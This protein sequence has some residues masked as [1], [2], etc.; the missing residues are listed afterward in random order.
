VPAALVLWALWRLWQRRHVVWNG[1]RTFLRDVWALLWGAVLDVVAMVWRILGSAS[2]SILNAAPAAIR[3]R[4]KT[5][6]RRG[7][8][9]G[10][11]WLRLRGLSARQLIL[12]FYVSLVQRAGL[13]GWERRSGQT[14]YEYSREL[15][16]KLPDRRD[17]VRTLTE[18]FVHAKYSRRPVE[19]EDARRA[20]R[21]WERI[22]GELQTRRQ[23]NRLASWFG[24]GGGQTG[25][26][27][28]TGQRDK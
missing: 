19:D 26:T 8:G 25:Q 7:G 28:Q 20:R 18:A 1:L 12:Y 15:E 2:P 24:L 21:P 6:A 5:R 3:Q 4:W 23:A 27:G 16:E 9:G 11:N 22:R 10:A 14:P 17:E 13:I